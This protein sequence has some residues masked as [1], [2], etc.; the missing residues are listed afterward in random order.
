M[1]RAEPMEANM[2]I[3]STFQEGDSYSAVT[4]IESDLNSAVTD[5]QENECDWIETI[6]THAIVWKIPTGYI[7]SSD[8]EIVGVYSVDEGNWIDYDLVSDKSEY[9]L[10]FEGNELTISPEKTSVGPNLTYFY[11]KN[12]LC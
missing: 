10:K 6:Y 9:I 3:V 12:K 7:P 11:K 4:F 8:T 5:V 1:K 2:F